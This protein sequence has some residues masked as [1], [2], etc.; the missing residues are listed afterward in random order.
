MQ[1]IA[2]QT[3][4]LQAFAGV[5]NGVHVDKGQRLE[6]RTYILPVPPSL[7]TRVR[8]ALVSSARAQ[9]GR[10]PLATVNSLND[11]FNPAEAIERRIER[12]GL[13]AKVGKA[14]PMFRVQV[15]VQA[16]APADSHWLGLFDRRHCDVFLLTARGAT[17]LAHYLRSEPR[18]LIKRAFSAFHYAFHLDHALGTNG[19]FASLVHA[20]RDLPEQGLYHWLGDDGIRRAF[21]EGDSDLA[22][23]G[24]GRY[25]T[26]HAEIGFHLEWDAGTEPP[27]RLRTKARTALRAA[28]GHVLWVAPRPGREQTIRSAL[29]RAATEPDESGRVAGFWTTHTGLLRTHGPLGE[30]WRGLEQDERRSLSTLPGRARGVLQIEDCLGKPG[31]WEHRPGGT[32]GM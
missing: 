9:E 4:A 29:E 12:A 10:D 2:E 11:R 15:L 24:Y 28:R 3:D 6:Q 14:E 13:W 17:V 8:R 19:F 16:Q 22:P 30:V 7:L 21:E 23:D 18:S 20:S 26:E 31:W 32:E 1:S 27:Q 5:L 25:L